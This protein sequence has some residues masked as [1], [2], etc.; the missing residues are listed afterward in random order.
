MWS[1]R[2]VWKEMKQLIQVWWAVFCH[3][4]TEGAGEIICETG[5][6]KLEN[7]FLILIFIK[8]KRIK[9]WIHF[10]IFAIWITKQDEETFE[11]GKF[12]WPNSKFLAV[13][14][15]W[16][17]CPEMSKCLT[18]SRWQKP[19]CHFSFRSHSVLKSHYVKSCCFKSSSCSLIT[20][21]VRF[22][23]SYPRSVNVSSRASVAD[24]FIQP[25]SVVPVQAVTAGA[26]L[27]SADNWITFG[28]TEAWIPSA[29]RSWCGK[30]E[31]CFW[32]P[33]YGH[34][35][36]TGKKNTYKIHYLYIKNTINNQEDFFLT[37]MIWGFFGLFFI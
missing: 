14:L 16:E 26:A 10:N 27:M 6:Q 5:W 11:S 22:L 13:A 24:L 36:H 29:C 1:S 3:L 15:L 18:T 12:L 35:W 34:G 37:K 30:E 25:S 32:I 17:G 31:S 8:R 21:V 7:W 28:N 2:T 33:D 19:K 9:Y 23:S 20:L 4:R